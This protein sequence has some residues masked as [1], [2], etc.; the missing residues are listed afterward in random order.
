MVTPMDLLQHAGLRRTRCREAVIGYFLEKGV[1]LAHAD[2]EQAL[3]AY[4]RVTLYRTL[5]TFME[6]QLLHKVVDDGAVVKY[7]LSET[8]H[9]HHHHVH[10]KCVQCQT[11]TCLAEVEAPRMSLPPA[12]EVHE[13]NLLLVGVCPTCH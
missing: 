11:T 1:A 2:L 7:A 12:Y 13:Q 10:F 4:D 9:E 8:A 3:P 6:H 5:A